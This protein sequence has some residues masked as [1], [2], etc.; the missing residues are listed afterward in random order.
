MKQFSG[1]IEGY[2]GK[3][4]SWDDRTKL[5]DALKRLSLN[6]YVYGPKEDPFHRILWK[7]SYPRE[8]ITQF[9]RF[10]KDAKKK[11][12][13]VVPGLA[14]GL[15]F[16]YRNAADYR[17][18]VKKFKSFVACGAETVSL[19]MDDIPETLPENCARTFSSLGNAHAVLLSRLQND[20]RDYN[21]AVSLWFCPTVY[22]DRFAKGPVDKNKYLLDLAAGIPGGVAVFWTGPS[23]ISESISE[24]AVAPISRLFSGNLI[25]WDNLYANDYCPSRLFVG[26]YRGR[27]R[28]LFT[29]V[30]GV[31]LNPTGLVQTDIM[32]LERLSA[33][34]GKNGKRPPIASG[35]PPVPP[36]F[37]TVARFFDLPFSRFT[38]DGLSSERVS[39]Y[40]KALKH[41]VWEWKSPLQREWYPFL[42]Q[43]DKDL[44]LLRRLR[45]KTLSREWIDKYYPPVLSL[46]LSQQLATGRRAFRC[47]KRKKT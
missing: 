8:W 34:A 44:T 10:V 18:L 24:K 3:L 5:L 4:L 6:T 31:C 42:L 27:S 46:F 32:L 11:N 33:F 9:T 37:R 14:P 7:C 28:G 12:I 25:I 41:L 15:S 23:V 26:P 20:L 16:D 43:L 45:E 19:F 2:Y 13:T 39:A 47:G 29:S 30:K 36:A 40:Q 38:A 21:P 1:Y 17:T 35:I 22:C